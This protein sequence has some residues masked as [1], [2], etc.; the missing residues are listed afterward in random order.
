MQISQVLNTVDS[1]YYAVLLVMAL[2]RIFDLLKNEINEF[3]ELYSVFY[4]ACL[5]VIC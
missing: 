5:L 4:N 2:P 3:H 1:P